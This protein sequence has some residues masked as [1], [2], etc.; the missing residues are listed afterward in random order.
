MDSTDTKGKRPTPKS[1]SKAP[2]ATHKDSG[3]AAIAKAR[4]SHKAAST[5]P[6]WAAIELD[7]RAGIKSL[8]QIA[9][10]HGLTDGAV[11]KR[12][13]RDGWDRDL[14]ARIQL[15]ADEL[16]RKE[17]V[18]AE[19]RAERAATERQVV[20]ANALAVADVRLA[21]RRDIQKANAITMALFRELEG[22]TGEEAVELLA[23]LGELL[24]CEDD[25]GID[26]LNDL[27]RK[28]I[29]LPERARTLKTLTDALKT[30][31]ELQ[32]QAFG[33][34][35]KAAGVDDQAGIGGARIA[36]EFVK[37]RPRTA[38]DEDES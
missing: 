29:S 2:E 11:R 22:Q 8:R 23:Q 27:Y 34:D 25:K 3:D 20:E 26:K 1:R 15:K 33:M 36:V 24:R 16:V 13:K 5:S 12:A 30:G 17:A 10:E 6:D 32:R 31:V 18:R 21:H 7:Y 9:G 28:A 19:V 4:E 14:S 35:T 38:D 37:A